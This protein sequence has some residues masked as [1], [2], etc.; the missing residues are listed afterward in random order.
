[1]YVRF[2][3]TFILL[4]YSIWVDCS[5]I[6]ARSRASLACPGWRREKRGNNRQ[7]RG[8]M[9]ED[10]DIFRK[11]CHVV[12]LW[13]LTRAAMDTFFE[14]QLICKMIHW[15]LNCSIKYKILKNCHSEFPKAQDDILKYLVLTTEMFS[16]QSQ[17]SYD[18]EDI[19]QSLL[20][21][22]HLTNVENV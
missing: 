15:L 14:W 22:L 11:Q 19:H 12:C 20:I 10:V 6:R 17:R 2:L 13:I 5:C 9:A 7:V 18:I 21:Y 4:W 8:V 3:H 1:M 16:S